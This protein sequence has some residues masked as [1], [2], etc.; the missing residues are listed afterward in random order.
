MNIDCVIFDLDGTLVQ[1][2]ETIYEAMCAALTDLNISYK[3]SKDDFYNKIGHH[4][5][6]IFNDMDIEVTDF[7]EFINIYKAHYFDFIN[8]SKL[9]PNVENTLIFL[10]EK[11]VKTSLL[12]TKGQDQAEKIIKHFQLEKHFNYIMGRRNGIDHKPSAEPLLKICSD[13]KLEPE[14]SMIVGDTEMDI[15]CGKNAGAKTCAV[16]F[17]YRSFSDIQ[18]ENPDYIIDKLPEV[19]NIVNGVK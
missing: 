6:D 10:N 19:K 18:R 9:Y 11:N 5:I 4:F 17:G 2:H 13:L 12:T 7:E 8:S 14:N 16:T 3:I 15:R 1:S